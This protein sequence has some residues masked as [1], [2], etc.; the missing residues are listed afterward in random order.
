M[1]QDDTLYKLTYLLTYYVCAAC[2]AD[3][4]G[5]KVIEDWICPSSN[6]S[7]R[8]P[9]DDD[10]SAGGARTNAQSSAVGGSPTSRE[11]DDGDAV[12]DGVEGTPMVAAYVGGTLAVLV[13]LLAVT[14]AVSYYFAARS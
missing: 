10:P 2:A 14:A 8:R 13:T 9:H 12:A 5:A 11:N 1:F 4:T 7:S 3:K 6:P